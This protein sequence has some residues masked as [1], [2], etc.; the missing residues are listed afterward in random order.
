VWQYDLFAVVAFITSMLVGCCVIP[1]VKYIFRRVKDPSLPERNQVM[2]GPSAS[3]P[4]SGEALRLGA[5]LA[6]LHAVQQAAR[7][8]DQHRES[9]FHAPLDPCCK[10]ALDRVLM[11][12]SPGQIMFIWGSI[13]WWGITPSCR[14]YLSHTHPNL[15]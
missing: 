4:G 6:D 5:G 1:E 11:T 15:W 9:F 8:A 14:N 13:I 10:V 3:P 7:R 12:M 2:I